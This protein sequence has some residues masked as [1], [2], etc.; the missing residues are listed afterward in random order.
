MRPVTE[1]ETPKAIHK[2]AI[3]YAK[4]ADLYN[5]RAVGDGVVMEKVYNITIFRK[6]IAGRGLVPGV[7]FEAFTKDG[8]TVVKR[9]STAVMSRG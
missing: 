8:E 7:D 3:D 6:N 1:V 9:L 2:A 5:E 4:L